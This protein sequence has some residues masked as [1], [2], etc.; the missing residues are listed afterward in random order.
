MDCIAFRDTCESQKI[1][2]FPTIIQYKDGKEVQRQKGSKDMPDM[3]KW[4]EDMLE[5]IRP[6]SRPKGGPKPPK[7]GDKSVE[8]GPE[9]KEQAEEA[10]EKEAE[11][12]QAGSAASSAWQD[13][14]TYD[15][16][17]AFGGA[18]TAHIQMLFL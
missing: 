17:W 10:Q 5:A 16:A 18:W 14:K 15:P 3:V 6:G 7:P 13:S 9:T 2:N 11:D 8:T 1:N 12:D 4:V